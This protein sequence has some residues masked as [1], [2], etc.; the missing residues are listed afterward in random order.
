MEEIIRRYQRDADESYSEYA[1]RVLRDRIMKCEL[2]PGTPINESELADILQVSRTPVHEALARLKDENLV[3]ILPRKESRVSKIDL[4]LV[5]DGIFIR[6]CV[7]P[8]LIRSAQGNLRSSIMQRML[9][10]INLQRQILLEGNKFNEFNEVDDEFHMLL[11]FAANRENT[12]WQVRKMVSHFDRV[13]YL[14]RTTE[15]FSEVDTNSFEEHRQIFAAI[16]YC[17]DLPTDAHTLIRRHITRFQTRMYE[18]MEKHED[19]FTGN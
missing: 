14:A 4:V 17:A 16:A 8:E 5:N 2:V 1:Y 7:E 15:G 6:N 18:I 9:R 10:N 13:R 3:D 11:F 12:Y 19:Y